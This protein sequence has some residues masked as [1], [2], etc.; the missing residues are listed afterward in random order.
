M[1][2]SDKLAEVIEQFMAKVSGE[3]ERGWAST[4]MAEAILQAGYLPVEEVQLE[5]LTEE[6]IGEKLDEEWDGLD[7]FSLAQFVQ[8]YTIDNILKG[9][10]LYR[11]KE[12]GEAKGD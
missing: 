10:K 6:E 12:K 5:G 4:G 9:G 11:V 3:D 2:D 8:N 7:Q 1:S